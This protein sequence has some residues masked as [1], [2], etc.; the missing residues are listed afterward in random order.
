MSYITS[1]L[2]SGLILSRIQRREPSSYTNHS[3]QESVIKEE[4]GSETRKTAI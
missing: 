2:F 1:R 4:A 3:N